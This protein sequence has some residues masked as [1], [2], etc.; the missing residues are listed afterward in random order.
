[1]ALI[2]DNPELLE[3]PPLYSTETEAIKVAADN[4]YRLRRG[5]DGPWLRFG[6][7]TAPCDVFIAYSHSGQWWL[8]IEHAGVARELSGASLSGPGIHTL[9]FDSL[10]EMHRTLDRAYHLSLSL[11]SAPLSAFE[12]ATEG[13]LRS[14]EAQRMVIMRV[15]QDIFRAALMDYWNC[16]CPLTGI[17]DP[18]LLRAS[19]IVPW[20]ECATDEMRLN[21]YNGLLLSPLW[22]AAFDAG[23]I[24][25]AADGSVLT[26][27]TLSEEAARTLQLEMRPRLHSLTPNHEALL[28]KHRTRH[29]YS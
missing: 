26:S 13:L 1:M 20:A 8:S 28:Q 14:T 21:V 22:D 16:R 11:P 17:T 7:T 18:A 4:G 27:P 3:E 25:F 10:Y 29:R 6:S 12:Q 24:S 9:S 19:H 5:T 23:L 15:G 2:S